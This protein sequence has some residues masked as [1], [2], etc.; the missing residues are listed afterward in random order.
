MLKSSKSNLE[1]LEQLFNEQG[2]TIRYEKGNFHS[3]YCIV[4]DSKV[5]VV[6]KFF[7]TEARINV[8]LDILSHS[9]VMEDALSEKSKVFYKYVLKSMEYQSIQS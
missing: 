5:I 7:D 4:N 3:G 8:F 2:Y 6:N 1:K 9:V